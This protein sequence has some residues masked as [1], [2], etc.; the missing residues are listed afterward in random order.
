MCKFRPS[1]HT[2]CLVPH[3]STLGRA[4]ARRRRPA[5]NTPRLDQLSPSA[6][7][8]SSHVAGASPRTTL[9]MGRMFGP[10]VPVSTD[11]RRSATRAAI[12]SQALGAP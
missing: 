8:V 6:L 12:A 4:A 5:L 10:T 9:L 7:R 3:L 2:K 1:T 11:R